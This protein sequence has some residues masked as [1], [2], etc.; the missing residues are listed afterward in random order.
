MTT[1]ID[2]VGTGSHMV[3]DSLVRRKRTSGKVN[4]IVREWSE[5]YELELMACAV[6]AAHNAT[7]A[8]NVNVP[9]G[10]S[11]SVCNGEHTLGTKM[12]Y[13][14]GTNTMYERGTNTTP[15]S[16]RAHPS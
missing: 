13:E 2:L 14:R 11:E 6:A 15:V 12:I 5:L 8:I 3:T 10:V 7:L 4:K 9:W 16:N 1:V